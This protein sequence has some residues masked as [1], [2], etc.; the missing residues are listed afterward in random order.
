MD[1]GNYR[2]IDHNEN[3]SITFKYVYISDMDE[4]GYFLV[5][6]ISGRKGYINLK[7]ES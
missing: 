4:Y 7:S 1:N 2:L 5:E 6:T 3:V